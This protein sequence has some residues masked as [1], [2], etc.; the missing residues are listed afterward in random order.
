MP[1]LRGLGIDWRGFY[2]DFAPD[3]ASEQTSYAVQ[4]TRTSSCLTVKS[5]CALSCEPSLN[6]KFNLLLRKC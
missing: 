4:V 5:F 1:P 2:N 3:G 6:Q